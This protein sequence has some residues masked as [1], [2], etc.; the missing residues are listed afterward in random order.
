MY[1][2]ISGAKG[3]YDKDYDK[4]SIAI[5]IDLIKA[6]QNPYPYQD[7]VETISHE[8]VHAIQHLMGGSY[9]LPSKHISNPEHT[10]DE[11]WDL[12]SRS[13]KSYP[14]HSLLDSE[15][16]P[17][18]ADR[19]AKLKSLKEQHPELDMAWFKGF[20]ERDSWLKILK[21]HAKEKYH[22]AVNEL[23]KVFQVV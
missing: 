13:K 1:Y 11:Y 19:A 23:L 16:Y 22:K 5:N 21:E 15:F 18:L 7:I 4:S 2:G 12:P 20:V 6:A 14:Y 10:L 17:R 3:T 8:L 9:G